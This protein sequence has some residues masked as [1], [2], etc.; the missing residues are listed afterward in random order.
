MSNIRWITAEG[1]LGTY[2]ENNEFSLRLEVQNPLTP[3][4]SAGF[5]P[6][7][8]VSGNGTVDQVRADINS[9]KTEWTFSSLGLPGS[10]LTGSFPNEENPYRITANSI[11]FSYPYR[12]GLNRPTDTF[13]PV[14]VAGPIAISSVG[15]YFYGPSAGIQISGDHGSSWT[16]NSVSTSVPASDVYGG[17]VSASGQYHYRDSSFITATA[18]QRIDQWK[19]GF[20]HPDGHSKIIGWAADGY[21][22]YGPYG[23]SEPLLPGAIVRMQSGYT[24]GVRPG[25]PRPTT[26]RIIPG[27]YNTTTINVENIAGLYAGQLLLGPWPEGTIKIVQVKPGQLQLNNRVPSEIK[28][29]LRVLATWPLGSFLEDYSYTAPPGTSLDT[30]NGRFCVTPDFPSGTYAYFMTEDLDGVPTYPYIIGSNYYGSTRSDDVS[31]IANTDPAPTATNFSILSGALPR[32]LQLQPNGLIYGFPQVVETGDNVARTYRFTAR[33]SNTR[34]QIA[35]R[36]FTLAVNKIIPPVLLPTGLRGE[37][38]SS[39]RGNIDLTFTNRGSGYFSANV[40]VN[41]GAPTSADGEAAIPGKVHLFAN[42]AIKNIGLIRPGTGYT[43]I[44]GISIT[45]ANTV[46]ASSEILKLTNNGREDLGYFFDGDPV[47][48][49]INALEVS[50]TGTLTWRVVQGSLPPGLALDQTGLI[51]GFALAPP[52]AGPAGTAAYDVGEYDEFVWD[53]EGVADS[54][55]YQFTIRIFDGINYVDQKYKMGIYD[56]TFFLVDNEVITVDTTLYTADRDGYQYPS[57]L[58]TGSQLPSVRQQQGYAFQFRAYYSNPNFR[59]RWSV[60]AGGPALFDQGAAPI[61]DDNGRF[62]TLVPYDNKSFDQSDLS[63]PSGIFIDLETGWLLGSLGTTTSQEQIYQFEVTAYVDIPVSQSVTSRRSSRPVTFQLKVLSDVED[64]VTWITDSD[65]GTIDN[66]QVSTLQIQATTTQQTPLVYRVKSGQ[67]L[68]IPQGLRI[69]SN[70]LISGRTSFDFFSLDRNI[71]EITFD[72]TTNTYDSRFTF[73]VIA[74][75]S[76]GTVYD[77]RSFFLTVKNVNKKPYENLYLKAL[78]PAP[79]R[80]VFRSIVTDERLSSDD[81]IYRTNDP[82]FGVHLDLTMLAQAGVRAEAA[83]VFIDAMADY[84]YE[85]KVNFGTIKKAVARN[86]DGSIKYE[87]LYVEVFDYNDKNLPGTTIARTNNLPRDLGSIDDV[88]LSKDDLQSVDDKNSRFEDFGSVDDDEIIGDNQVYSNSFANM[89]GE[90]E[91][92]IGYEFQGALPDWMISVQPETG[93]PLG[94]VRALVLAYAKPGQGDRLLYRYQASLEQSGYGVSDIM[95]TFRFVADR[96]QWDRTLSVNYDAATG[97]FLPSVTTTFDRVPAAGILDKGAW[98]PRD[99]NVGS[100]LFSIAYGAGYYIA[101][102]ANS[103]IATSTSGSAWFVE[104]QRADLSYDLGIV[105]AVPSGSTRLIFSYNEELSVGDEVLRQD[106]FDSNSRSY[107]SSVQYAVRLSAN[108]ANTISAGTSIEFVNYR[109]GTTLQLPLGVTALAGNNVLHFANISSIERGFEIYQAGIDL[110]NAANVISVTNDTVTVFRSTT[111]VIPAGT[112]IE[113]DNLAG[114]VYIATTVGSTSANSNVIVFSGNLEFLTSG[115]YLR[116]ASMNKNTSV[117]SKFTY[118]DITEGPLSTVPAGAELSFNHRITANASVGDSVIY[119]SNTSKLAV[120][121]EVYSATTESNTT[122]RASWP[123][124]VVP[125]TEL[126]ISV[127]LEAINGDIFPGMRVVGPDVPASS[128]IREIAANASYANIQI[129]FASTTITARSNVALSFLTPTVVIPGTTIVGKTSTSILLSDPLTSD[130]SIG[131]DRTISF[132]LTNVNLN[133]VIYTGEK[134][135][136]VGDKGLIIDKEPT[137]RGWAQRFGL[138][139][140]DLQSVYYSYNSG[141]DSYMYIAVGNEGVVIRST[142]IDT[143]SLPIAT[144]ANRTLRAVHHYLGEWI[145]VGDGGQVLNSVDD[146][147]TWTL[148]TSTTDLNLYDIK[149]LNGQWIMV[150]D[151]GFVW[152]KPAGG[153]SWTRYNIGATDGL[154]SVSF[155]NNSYYVVG[156]RGTIATSLDGTRWQL[157]DRFTFNRLNS[158]SKD[159]TVAVV[160]G[161]QGTILSESP[162]FTVN[163]AVRNIAFDQFNLRSQPNLS[164]LGYDVKP[165]DTLIFA[166]QEGFGGVNDGWNR[167]T[168]SFGIEPDG[169]SGYDTGNFDSLETIPGYVESLNTSVSN[170]RAGIWRVSISDQELVS[171]EFQRQILPGQVVTAI[172]ETTRLIYDPLIKPG[173]T[174]PEYSLIGSSL[175]DS[176]QNTSFDEEGTRFVNNKTSYTAPGDLDQYLKFPKTGVFR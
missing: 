170:Q 24:A 151:N 41:I 166:Q 67:Y 96:Y 117:Q 6:R 81:I 71:S 97:K 14:P 20:R 135:L 54:R 36:T 59:V 48:L 155:I 34:G 51:S 47:S 156:N 176:T 63:L 78:L 21:P 27:I 142:D 120:G 167:Y 84:H 66:G 106:L 88:F 5:D 99:I 18:W 109:N 122:D 3:D 50:P 37:G 171:L 61:P 139:Y 148:D 92:G 64:L 175:A 126:F 69:L 110:A 112:A 123:A 121:T 55:V 105:S 147:I 2:A 158:I 85:K 89:R 72:K 98:L 80:Q 57:I 17:A 116:M 140:G 131:G 114:N 74:E 49:K 103:V 19:S 133:T 132:G 77:E 159:A 173:K 107:I 7:D 146:G 31:G 52:A 108:L 115:H 32:G 154:R 129:K 39:T 62:F 87:V 35:D 33:A 100:G 143:W 73:T 144:L 138:V 83:A 30:K 1:D 152:L 153:N 26:V 104:S 75:D 15:I 82:Y 125:G 12:G 16:I 13:E 46:A 127:P 91:R 93:V 29:G 53:F 162:N 145:A 128:V 172:N 79:L 149:Y 174:V 161:Q 4:K 113:F 163:W 101:V 25:R 111:A 45:G 9:S 168:E 56:K 68:R 22:V 23:Y 119:I 70:G 40:T 141:S 43:T 65:L 165:G 10:V 58:T 8:S 86:I 150:G 60:N 11:E 102:G 94:F 38:I 130:I 137:D 124:L 76:T 157:A 90:I 44:P 136:A 118:A 164:R 42:G 160:V 28:P 134:W 95:N 169:T